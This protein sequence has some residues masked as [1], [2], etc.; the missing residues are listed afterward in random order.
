MRKSLTYLAVAFASSLRMRM[1]LAL[2]CLAKAFSRL[3]AKRA[4]WLFRE[5]WWR[6]GIRVKSIYAVKYART[7]INSQPN[8]EE[9]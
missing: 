6:D 4:F 9:H 5:R 1:A 3:M 7:F 2:R 8:Y